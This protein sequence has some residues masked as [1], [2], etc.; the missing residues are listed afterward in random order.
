MAYDDE[1]SISLPR[2][3]HGA[4]F[5]EDANDLFDGVPINLTG[6]VNDIKS[7]KS[8]DIP[9]DEVAVFDPRSYQMEMY[10]E[11]LRRNIIVTMDTGSG[12]THIAV[13]RIRAELENALHSKMVWFMAPT[14][15]LC[16]QQYLVIKNHFSAAQVKFLSSLDNVDRWS[17]KSLWDTFLMNVRVVVSTPQ[18]L[19]DA[20]THGFVRLESIAL[21]VF[22]E[23]KPRSASLKDIYSGELTKVAHNCVGKN[24][25]SKIMGD[26]YERRKSQNL[27]VPNILGLS[28]SPIMNSKLQSLEKIEA[29]LDA[30]CRAPTVHRA[31]LMT[32][33][34]IPEVCLMAYDVGP[35]PFELAT[36]PSSLTNLFK[37]YQ[38]LDIKKDP[39]IVHLQGE[40]TEK[41]QRQLLKALAKRKTWCQDQM[42]SFCNTTL[43]IY[44]ELGV[45]AAE[46]YISRV[47]SGY[48]ERIETEAASFWDITTEEKRYLADLFR[49]L[50]IAEIAG[51]EAHMM[52]ISSDKVI[53]F[54]EAL[55]KDG[56]SVGI[57]FAE[58]R[59]TV[60]VLAKL[61]ATYPATGNRFRVGTMVGSSQY[62]Q[63]NK[64]ISDLISPE[65]QRDTLDKFRTG[66]LDLLIAT[67]ALEEGI[68]V[69]A[70]NMVICF[71]APANLKSFVQR[72]GRARMRESK[73]ILMQGSVSNRLAEW[74]A[75]EGEMKSIYANDMRQLRALEELERLEEHDGREFRISSTGA[76]LTL[77]NAVSHLYHFCAV[78][79]AN[80]YIDVRPEFI[81]LPLQKTKV[82]LPLSVDESVR[83]AHS[84]YVWASEKNG[85]KD[86]AFE[87]YIALYHAGLVNEHLLPLLRH[88]VVE[89]GLATAIE[90][91][92]SLVNVQDALNPWHDIAKAWS[93]PAD[94]FRRSLVTLCEANRETSLSM[95]IILPIEMPQ[96]PWF[97]VYWD[98]D[99]K[100]IVSVS[101][102]MAEVTDTFLSRAQGV[103]RKVL[104]AAFGHRFS[105][106]RADLVMPFIPSAS[107]D[108]FSEQLDVEPVQSRFQLSSR[109]SAIGLIRDK[110]EASVRYLF[111]DWLDHK[112]PLSLIKNPYSGYEDVMEDTPHLVLS[113]LTRREDFLH[114]VSLD[115]IQPSEKQYSY[116]LP[117]S[118]CM[119]ERI[120]FSHVQLGMLLP[121]IMHRIKVYL[122]AGAL[123]QT[124][125]RDVGYGDLSPVVTAM[126][127]SSASGTDNYQR[128]EF[129][130][131]S[132]LKTCTSLQ[133][134]A[135]YPRWHEGYLS[136]KK[137]RLVANSRLA[138]AAVDVGLDRFIL[139]KRFTGRKWRPSY[140]KDCLEGNEGPRTREMSSKVL[141]DVVEA[142]IGAAMFDGGFPKALACIRVFLPDITWKS[143]EERRAS[144]YEEVA[145]EIP[146][147]ALLQPLESLIGYE[148]K[149]KSLLIES[150]THASCHSG[151]ASLERLEFLGDAILDNI[152]VQSIYSYRPEL[153]HVSMHHLR[154][155]FVNADFLAFMCMEWSISQETGSVTEDR[156]TH[157]F[158]PALSTTSLALWTFLRHSS[159]KLTLVQQSTAERHR[160]LRDEI[161][162]AMEHGSHYPWALL[163]RLD[164]QKFYSDMVEALLGAVYI[165]SGSFSCCEAILERM[166]VMR[167]LRRVLADEV[168][169][170]HPK[171]ELGMLADTEAVKY[172][173]GLEKKIV[174]TVEQR[175]YTCEV[176]VGERRVVIMG[177]G[178]GRA[179]IRVRA[180]EEAV[181]LLKLE[182]DVEKSKKEV[183]G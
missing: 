68:D 141:A 3:K 120:P 43:V 33:V 17:E 137:D 77:D 24:A 156:T 22:D 69:P 146:L 169:L 9:S 81:F 37:L 129:L 109:G 80:A 46:Y 88:D 93:F 179:E 183:D 6:E 113:R 10:E 100:M 130:G 170:L 149:K 161:V 49:G 89:E 95:E 117:V 84:R 151:R 27:S 138:R 2:P 5:S 148:F 131:D 25:G 111:E 36:Y 136:A 173:P 29:T 107:N 152:I 59:A 123:S 145:A 41:S 62:G 163:A 64:T 125:L 51:R 60:A 103:S 32:H 56:D 1:A 83:T 63:R 11:S 175:E 94:H 20:L 74:Q 85:I 44:D 171:E 143:L 134:M 26:F 57:V 99:S 144:V 178:I 19:L 182:K 73:L 4:A 116:V 14:V 61:L 140:V 67:S 124:L 55:P 47:V 155:V 42:K 91:R 39:Y 76:L 110:G 121:S 133:L 31:E 52:E 79:P 53:R 28:A 50:E 119:I 45:W 30:I 166:G 128:L 96:M 34:N 154:T 153:T 92:P 115:N 7:P 158:S 101:P 58:R 70:C 160:W 142:L 18:I 71:D 157:T 48:L 97:P 165:D 23:G 106:E 180:A 35:S 38:N 87:A 168:H 54:I 108:D 167:Y 105:I 21:L 15:S 104:E 13:L 8:V 139:T 112:A 72:R 16:E 40:A 66:Q 114:P 82:I 177:G 127:A 172:V 86:V 102:T 98:V 147:P 181:R 150:M 176:W 174:G 126:T 159:R 135:E 65:D 122:L 12:K 78:L 132:V 162:A 118:R 90:K 75:L 164:A